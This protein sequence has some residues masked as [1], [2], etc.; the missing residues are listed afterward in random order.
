V[1]KPDVGQPV[2]KCGSAEPRK[3]EASPLALLER[4]GGAFLE[5][6]PLGR[7]GGPADLKGTVVFLASDASDFVTGQTI[8]VDGGQSVA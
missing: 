4:S 1:V 8:V 3:R 7:F 2:R 5:R 6:I